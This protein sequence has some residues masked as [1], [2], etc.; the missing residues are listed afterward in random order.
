MDFF[1]LGIIAVVIAISLVLI[2]ANKNSKT[3]A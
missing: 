1:Y 3:T 2:I